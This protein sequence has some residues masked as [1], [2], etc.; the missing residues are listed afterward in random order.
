MTDISTY[1]PITVVGATTWG[2]TLAILRYR[3][4]AGRAGHSGL[5]AV[6]LHRPMAGR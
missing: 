3:T 4:L 5:F 1:P 2:T 6:H